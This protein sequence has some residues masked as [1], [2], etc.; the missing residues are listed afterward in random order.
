[1]YDYINNLSHDLINYIYDY[2]PYNILLIL[3]KT[4]YNR[5]YNHRINYIKNTICKGKNK[6]FTYDTYI[7]RIVKNDMIFIF[8][9]L[10]IMEH[11]RWERKS[12]KKYKYKNKIFKKYIDFLKYLSIKH[13]S[14]KCLNIMNE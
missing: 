2:I 3:N 1:M 5:Y 12:K 8:E 9:K 10:Y 13:K 7:H 4:Y 11:E 14:Q 6:L